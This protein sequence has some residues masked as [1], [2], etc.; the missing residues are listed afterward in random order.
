[1]PRVQNVGTGALQNFGRNDY[2]VRNNNNDRNPRLNVLY[3]LKYCHAM[4]RIKI[5]HRTEV[6]RLFAGHTVFFASKSPA[7]VLKNKCA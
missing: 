7:Y 5:R 2:I 4:M 1:M 6:Y 3:S